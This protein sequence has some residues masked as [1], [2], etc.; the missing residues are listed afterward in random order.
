VTECTGSVSGVDDD[1]LKHRYNSA[2]DP[3]LNGS[4]SQALSLAFLIA[5]RMRLRTGLPPL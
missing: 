4:Q 2:C 3:R 1:T 5:E